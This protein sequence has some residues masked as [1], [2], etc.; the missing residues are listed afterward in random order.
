MNIIET[1]ESPIPEMLDPNSDIYV[2]GKVVNYGYFYFY[3]KKEVYTKAILTIQ[4]NE[5]NERLI[6]VLWVKIK[7]PNF[8]NMTENLNNNQNS[9]SAKLHSS[10]LFYDTKEDMEI[11]VEFKMGKEITQPIIRIKKEDTVLF[12]E[13][14]GGIKKEKYLMIQEVLNGKKN[15]PKVINS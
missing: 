2:E 13:Y 10:I 9:V 1:I 3:D 8:I 7:I 15:F 12:K 6:W 14:S 4:Q 11:D 5:T